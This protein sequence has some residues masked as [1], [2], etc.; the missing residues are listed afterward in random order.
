M[1]NVILIFTDLQTKSRIVV[2]VRLNY[3]ARLVDHHGTHQ[4]FKGI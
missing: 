3:L 4:A 2:T 1:I